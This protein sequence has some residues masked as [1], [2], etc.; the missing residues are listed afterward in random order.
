VKVQIDVAAVLAAELDRLVHG[1]DRVLIDRH[2]VEDSP[3]NG[4]SSTVFRPMSDS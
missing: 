1:L 4:T 2:P 3:V